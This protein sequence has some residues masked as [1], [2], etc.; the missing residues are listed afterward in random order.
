MVALDHSVCPTL[1]PKMSL[2]LGGASLLQGRSSQ[3]KLRGGA[4]ERAER[5]DFSAQLPLSAQG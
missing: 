3:P 1:L 4:A 2:L 5:L